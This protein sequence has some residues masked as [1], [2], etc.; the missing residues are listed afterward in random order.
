MIGLV[1]SGEFGLALLRRVIGACGRF[2]RRQYV[3]GLPWVGAV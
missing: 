1:N 3:V 2:R